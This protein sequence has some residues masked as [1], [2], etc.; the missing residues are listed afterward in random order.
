MDWTQIYDPL[1]NAFLS[2]A[3]AAFPIVV[4]LGGLAFFHLRAHVAALLGLA[5]AMA[6]AIGVFGMPATLAF[7][8]AGYGAAY[9]LLPIGWHHSPD[10]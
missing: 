1:D 2:T 7:A 8:T 4:L 10:G 6:V 3:L 9:G 5:S